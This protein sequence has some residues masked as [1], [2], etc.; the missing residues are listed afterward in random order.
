[1]G[2]ALIEDEHRACAACHTTQATTV[3]VGTERQS[4]LQTKHTDN[5]MPNTYFEY[6]CRMYV[7]KSAGSRAA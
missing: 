7:S 3:K 4:R 5:V 6:F 1:M 2:D